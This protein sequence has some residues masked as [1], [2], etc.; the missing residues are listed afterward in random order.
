MV[1][2]DTWIREQAQENQMIQPFVEALQ[3]EGVLSFGLSSAGYDIRIAD[4]YKIFANVYGTVVIDPKQIDSLAYVDH[5]GPTCVIPPHSF[6][7]GR[8]IEFIKMPDTVLGFLQPKSTY[9]RSGILTPSTV[10]E[11]GW[12]GF[13]TLEI[14]NMSA[15]PAKVYSWE[16]IA[17]LVFL[18]IEGNPETTYA[19]RG[20]KYQYQQ[21]ITLPKV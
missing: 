9:I 21:G 4:E 15:L 5:T 16:G 2:P 12:E 7:L 1:M 6:V 17:Q 8:S 18:S 3:T 13:I 20:G 11:P 14:A 19:S 10:L